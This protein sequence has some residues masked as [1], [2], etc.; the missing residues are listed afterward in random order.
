MIGSGSKD[1]KGLNVNKYGEAATEHDNAGAIAHYAA[2]RSSDVAGP[3]GALNTGAT[4]DCDA[5]V[6]PPVPIGTLPPGFWEARAL[7]K[8]QVEAARRRKKDSTADDPP[9]G[10]RPVPPRG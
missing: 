4:P 3:G 8:S 2:I 6:E 7:L 10:A 9:P 1:V 5:W